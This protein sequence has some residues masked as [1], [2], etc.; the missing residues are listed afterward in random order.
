M[1]AIKKQLD[2][3][4]YGTAKF[5]RENI[6]PVFD[7]HWIK[8]SG[9]G[10]WASPVGAEYGWKQWCEDWTFNVESLKLK[11]LLTFVGNVITI[12]CAKDL[13]RLEWHCHPGSMFGKEGIC[14]ASM[15]RAGVDAIHL[16]TRGQEQTRHSMPRSLYGW[17]CE[18]V[19]IMNPETLTALPASI[20][21][22]V[23]EIK[24]S[25]VPVRRRRIT[26][27]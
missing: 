26:I 25:Y 11:T 27:R 24:P 15:K 2:L 9:G 23:S 8:P 5:D 1:S 4:H 3:I 17:D 19:L 12:D 21:I 16:T 18:S 20:E 6:R 13:E 22:E 10:F 7:S 14:F